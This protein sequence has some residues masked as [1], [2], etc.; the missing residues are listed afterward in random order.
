MTKEDK[1]FRCFGCANLQKD[2]CVKDENAPTSIFEIEECEEFLCPK[3]C[4]CDTQ[5]G[6]PLHCEP[7]PEELEF[8]LFEVIIN[9]KEKESDN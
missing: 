7:G 5:E 2:M 1:L 3:N 4:S 9:S 8:Y 6:E